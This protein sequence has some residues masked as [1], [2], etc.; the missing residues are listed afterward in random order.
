MTMARM[1]RK[2]KTVRTIPA[3]ISAFGGRPATADLFGVGVTCVHNW[4]A[5]NYISPAWHYRMHLAAELRGFHIDPA[6]FGVD[7]R[8]L[9]SHDRKVA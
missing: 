3:M 8:D 7:V 6:T 2:Q 5:D 1:S 4:V 9:L